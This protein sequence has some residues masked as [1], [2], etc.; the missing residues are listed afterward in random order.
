MSSA[1]IIRKLQ[2]S[3]LLPMRYKL[4]ANTSE[5]G[6]FFFSFI[7]LVGMVVVVM[8]VVTVVMRHGWG[9]LG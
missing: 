5:S 2:W 6:K 9:S 1:D 8:M 3:I 7:W 4:S